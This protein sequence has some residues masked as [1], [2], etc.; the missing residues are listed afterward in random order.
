[1]RAEG[2]EP[3]NLAAPAP[4]A[5]VSANS[6]TPARE[7]VS[8]YGAQDFGQTCWSSRA[9]LW[10]CEIEML[11]WLDCVQRSPSCSQVAQKIPRMSAERFEKNQR[12]YSYSATRPLG[13]LVLKRLIVRQP[14]ECR[15]PR[16]NVH[17]CSSTIACCQ[18][19]RTI[20]RLCLRPGPCCGNTS[21]QRFHEQSIRTQL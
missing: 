5:G 18:G 19:S 2:L 11:R 14:S 3:P 4:K 1:M 6:T 9:T 7:G 16:R 20:G 15:R 12:G 21:G 8:S 17:G 10:R 13:S